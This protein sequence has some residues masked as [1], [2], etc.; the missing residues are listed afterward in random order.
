MIPWNFLSVMI[1]ISHMTQDKRTTALISSFT[2][3]HF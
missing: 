2:L 3:S 1:V